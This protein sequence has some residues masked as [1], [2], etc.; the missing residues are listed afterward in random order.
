MSVLQGSATARLPL[1]PLYLTGPEKRQLQPVEEAT[2][3]QEA[4]ALKPKL[5][6]SNLA[7]KQASYNAE[8]QA[9]CHTYLWCPRQAE[10]GPPMASPQSRSLG[11][12]MEF[13]QM[14]VAERAQEAPALK[15]AATQGQSLVCRQSIPPS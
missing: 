6:F 7:S 15:T 4:D 8:M 3:H 11:Q 12:Q 1:L 14:P 10:A 13:P 5:T 2:E 9:Q